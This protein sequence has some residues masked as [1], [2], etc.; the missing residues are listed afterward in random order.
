MSGWTKSDDMAEDGRLTGDTL[1]GSDETRCQRV[2]RRFKENILLVLTA[3]GILLGFLLG[4]TLRLAEPSKDTVRWIG[5]PG[6][7]FLRMLKM[8]ITPLV[9]SSVITG[10][11][12]LDPRVNGKISIVSLIHLVITNIMGTIIGCSVVL[13]AKPGVGINVK[14]EAAKEVQK[15]RTQDIFADLIRNIFPDNLV[16][17]TMQQTKTDFKA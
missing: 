17:A 7:I 1:S 15:M 4:F 16:R 2:C 10:T 12:T 8:M 5:F 13:A 6:K 9:V 14:D 3:V 11:A